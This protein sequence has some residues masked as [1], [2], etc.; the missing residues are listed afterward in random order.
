MKACISASAPSDQPQLQNARRGDSR[1]VR[2][3]MSQLDPGASPDATPHPSLCSRPSL[4]G[5]G[6]S[7]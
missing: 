3:V 1:G 5:P 2:S 7:I 4:K 6:N